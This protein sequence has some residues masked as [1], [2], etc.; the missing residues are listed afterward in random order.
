MH[1]GVELGVSPNV[2]HPL[3]VHDHDLV[4]AVLVRPV[5]E[6]L[7]RVAPVVGPVVVV[8]V[9]STRVMQPQPAAVSGDAVLHVIAG[10]ERFN[11][12]YGLP[13]SL[14]Q[15]QTTTRHGARNYDACDVT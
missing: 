1:C 4:R 11:R 14:S 10:H 3:Y 5:R 2:A 8:V 12:H 7:R 6:G 15:L 13:L 9:P